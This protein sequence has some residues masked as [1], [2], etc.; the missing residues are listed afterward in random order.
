MARAA[1][2]AAGLL[3]FCTRA[4]VGAV[5][6]QQHQSHDA[7]TVAEEDA[8]GS[9]AESPQTCTELVN[10]GAFF[11]VDV[12]VGTPG[13]RFS[14]VA[15]TGSNTL[16]VPSCICQKSGYCSRKDRCFLG[17]NRS[18]SFSLVMDGG[19]PRG[20]LI[21]FG[22]G[23]I[24]GVIARE[25]ARVGGLEVNMSK[26]VML[27]TRKVL[28]FDESFE[29]IM[30]L[31]IPRE[32]KPVDHIGHKGPH[33]DI[34]ASSAGNVDQILKW[35]RGIFGG[36]Q[37]PNVAHAGRA[38]SA[39]AAERAGA[40]RAPP[41][42]LEQ[43]GVGRF[44]ICFNEGSNGVLRLGP[45]KT[46]NTDWHASVGVEHWGL[47]F[48]GISVAGAKMVHMDF[49]DPKDMRKHQ[50]TPCAAIPDSGTTMITGPREQL[51]ALLGSICDNWSRCSQNH[52]AMVKA[53]KA[54]EAAAVEELGFN[55][56]DLKPWT[57][58][59][60]MEALLED[61][62]DWLN[63]STGLNEMP[64]LHFHVVGGAGKKQTLAMPGQAYVIETTYELKG[65]LSKKIK[66]NGSSALENITDAWL[67]YTGG[68]TKVCAPAFDV[69]DYDTKRNGPVWILGMPFFYEYNVGYDLSSKP[70][71]ISF[72][73]VKQ[74]PC[75]SCDK[76]LG[77][78]SS[79]VDSVVHNANAAQ[80][81][82]PRWLS[83][84]AR[85][86]S[87]DLGRPL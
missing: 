52:T 6:L 13:Q 46:P 16:I 38:V 47:D 30:G 53:A 86:P 80:L 9:S 4:A 54:A 40:M 12:E 55:P 20:V 67:K 78:V 59:K 26:G 32:D 72:Q 19:Q 1:G 35:L 58:V 21:S 42:L 57:K 70:P 37:I 5:L 28:N 29:G 81:H 7:T 75:G 74:A 60:I 25:N 15:D 33:R 18:S 23:T 68:R 56:F 66:G 84:P 43:A 11:T 41:G 24:T 79:N 51:S 48:R 83:G 71:A 36:A 8:N 39:A 73:S 34:D 87:F 17:T 10:R 63:E 65:N 31:G 45:P 27:M 61:C 64:D 22:S 69:L 76:K 49:C 77:L 3:A 50:Q 2:Q 62:E 14:V 82:R 85:G 44:A